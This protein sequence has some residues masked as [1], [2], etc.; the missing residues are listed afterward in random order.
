MEQYVNQDKMEYFYY[1]EGIYCSFQ[2][3][4]YATRRYHTI[5]AKYRDSH[6]FNSEY[7]IKFLYYQINEKEWMEEAI[8]MRLTKD[9]GGP[10]FNNLYNTVNNIGNNN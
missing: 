1:M 6:Y 4:L 7:L 5:D 10:F 9:Y 3:A 2:C 8:D